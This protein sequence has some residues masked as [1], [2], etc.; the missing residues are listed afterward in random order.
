[1]KINNIVFFAA[2]LICSWSRE[3]NP[4]NSFIP[5]APTSLAATA[6]S[7]SQADLLWFDNSTDEDGFVIQRRLDGGNFINIDSVAANL[8][9]YSFTG[10]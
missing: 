3:N 7:V 9:A 2:F 8:I 10:I 6:I 1:M 5:S 4:V